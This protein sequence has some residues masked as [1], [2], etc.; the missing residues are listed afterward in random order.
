M[1]GW[2]KRAFRQE[3]LDKLATDRA[4]ELRSKRKHQFRGLY[5]LI[6]EDGGKREVGLAECPDEGRIS[7]VK[8]DAL[9][10][11][12]TKKDSLANP[13]RGLAVFVALFTYQLR[14][15]V[16]GNSPPPGTSPTSR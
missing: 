16:E 11:V 15:T 5:V 1:T 4:D 14:E 9:R 13:D 3:E 2:R 10:D 7:W 6:V 12:L 8:R